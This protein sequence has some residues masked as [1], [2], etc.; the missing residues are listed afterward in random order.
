M[1]IHLRTYIGIMIRK[2]VKPM[3]PSSPVS[4]GVDWGKR[5][6]EMIADG[7]LILEKVENGKRMYK[8]NRKRLGMDEVVEEEKPRTIGVPIVNEEEVFEDDELKA[9]SVK[10]PKKKTLDSAIKRLELLNKKT[11]RTTPA[12]HQK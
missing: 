5:L 6:S 3:V 10:I 1:Y 7:R 4:S 12:I 9:K 2:I 11:K 8:L